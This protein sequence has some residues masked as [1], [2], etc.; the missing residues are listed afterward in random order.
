MNATR[1]LPD[2]QCSLMCDEVR[3]EMSGNFILLGIIAYVRVPQLPITALKLCVFNRWTAGIGQFTETVR[4]IG[5][6]ETVMRQSQVRFALQEASHNATN[7]TLFTQV[8]F[9]AAGTY[10]VEVLVDDV[11]K[12]RF[13]VPVIHVQQQAQPGQPQRGPSPK[14]PEGPQAG[15]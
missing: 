3:Q 4:L 1:I 12:L 9:K 14:P 8:E 2:L 15:S 6:D 11:M 7:V 10:Y 13:P 5:P